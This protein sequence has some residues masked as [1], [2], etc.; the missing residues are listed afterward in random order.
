MTTPRVRMTFL[1]ILLA[2]P[3]GMVI[4][5]VWLYRL[6]GTE[7]T[8]SWSMAVAP[9]IVIFAV[10]FVAGGTIF[11]LAAHFWTTMPDPASPPADPDLAAA[12]RAIVEYQP[13]PLGVDLYTQIAMNAISVARAALDR[14][15]SAS[16][17]ARP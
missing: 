6:G 7:M 4:W 15:R 16:G 3:V 17:E 13:D 9:R 1:A 12:L 10:G 11:G 8:I 5:D 2:I 14:R